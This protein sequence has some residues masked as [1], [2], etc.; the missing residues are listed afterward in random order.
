MVQFCAF[1][2]KGP[3]GHISP[4]PGGLASGPRR[5]HRGSQEGVLAAAFTMRDDIGGGAMAPVPVT[6]QHV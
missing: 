2:P 4:D 3:G 5:S 1:A 6:T